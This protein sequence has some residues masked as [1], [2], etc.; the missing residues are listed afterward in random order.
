MIHYFLTAVNIVDSLDNHVAIMYNV[1]M[2][3]QPEEVMSIRIIEQGP[4]TIKV[5]IDGAVYRVRNYDSVP[6][7]SRFG[8]SQWPYQVDMHERAR[9][10]D[11]L[12]EE[13]ADEAPFPQ[14]YDEVYGPR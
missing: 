12:A 1:S 5:D 9:V 8:V 4:S 7:V 13:W 10:L 3:N 6:V 11:R 2:T 14:S